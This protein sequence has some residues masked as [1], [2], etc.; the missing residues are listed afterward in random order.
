MTAI[1]GCGQVS[2]A[3]EAS[4]AVRAGTDPASATASRPALDNERIARVKEALAAG[5]YPVD[6]VRLAERLVATGLFPGS[7]R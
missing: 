2:A 7:G 1:T 3:G 5:R 4:G 6:A